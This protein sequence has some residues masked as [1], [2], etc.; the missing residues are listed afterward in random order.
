MPAD[1]LLEPPYWNWWVLGIVLMVL[2]VVVPGTVLLW[3]GVA[4]LVV[5]LA[6]LAF[7]ELSTAFQWLLF[8]LVSVGAVLGWRGLFQAETAPG[9]DPLLNRGGHQYIGRILVVEVPIV[10]GT[11]RVK[12]ADGTWKALGPDCPAGSRV[13]V[14]GVAGTSLQVEPLEGVD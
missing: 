10:N 8:A 3:A 14:V 5:G 1:W 11:G 6:V 9:G 4:A 12:V 13:R 2:E 7:P